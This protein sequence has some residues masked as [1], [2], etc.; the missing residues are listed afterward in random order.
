MSNFS[1]HNKI[2]FNF[3]RNRSHRRRSSSGPRNQSKVQVATPPKIAKNIDR[4]SPNGIEAAPPARKK[5]EEGDDIAELERR[6]LE[7]KKVLEVMVNE[8]MKEK[9]RSTSSEDQKRIKRSRKP[10]QDSRSD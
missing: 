4:K 1:S 8:K 3:N 7:A 9:R 5:K 2:N 10:R 6:V